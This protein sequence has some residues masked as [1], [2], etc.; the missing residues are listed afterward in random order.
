MRRREFIA[1]VGVAVTWPLAVR[2]QQPAMPLIGLLG[3]ATAS[4]WVPGFSKTDW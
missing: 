3:S 4:G 2:A 1:L